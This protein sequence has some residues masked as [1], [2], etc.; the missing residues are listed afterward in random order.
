MLKVKPAKNVAMVAHPEKN[1][2]IAAL[3]PSS[4]ELLINGRVR[5]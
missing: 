2:S 5:W 3:K 1:V 4:F